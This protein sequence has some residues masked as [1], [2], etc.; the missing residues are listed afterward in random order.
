MQIHLHL[1]T[2]KWPW[3]G[4]H[5]SI[6]D[7]LGRPRKTQLAM[8]SY[9]IDIIVYVLYPCEKYEYS[10]LNFGMFS[11]NRKKTVHT[12]INKFRRKQAHCWRKKNQIQNARC[13]L[14]RNWMKLAVGLDFPNVNPSM[15]CTGDQG[16]K[17][18]ISSLLFFCYYLNGLCMWFSWHV[19]L[20]TV[21]WTQTHPERFDP[22][23]F[24]SLPPKWLKN[25]LQALK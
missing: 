10:G 17:F 5:F 22:G 12:L 14:K 21:L 6:T 7:V 16:L 25:F 2:H 19:G 18:R 1:V 13:W 11:Q 4:S 3:E 24:F 9:N 20:L 15:P 23:R 8:S